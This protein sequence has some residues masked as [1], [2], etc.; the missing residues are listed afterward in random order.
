MILT[1]SAIGGDVAWLQ[2][3]FLCVLVSVW[4]AGC[5]WLWLAGWL[6]VAG[7]GWLAGAG[8]G[9]TNVLR[10]F[11]SDSQNS[12]TVCNLT[13]EMVNVLQIGDPGG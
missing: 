11:R 6:A 12:C 5:G 8:A 9:A 7:C 4:L 2:A 3:L 1:L 10:I 13:L